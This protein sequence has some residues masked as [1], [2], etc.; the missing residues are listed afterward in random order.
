MLAVVAFRDTDMPAAIAV[1][2]RAEPNAASH[3][4]PSFFAGLDQV[5]RPGKLRRSKA[6]K[7]DFR[8]GFRTNK[9]P[10]NWF[11]Y[12]R[13][14]NGFGGYP[15]RIRPDTKS[16]FSEVFGSVRRRRTSPNTY[17]VPRRGLEPPRLAALVPETSASTN[18]AIW[19]R[20]GQPGRR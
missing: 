16:I 17:L 4:R 6:W 8:E 11:A 14:T 19:A 3:R 1:I 9:H 5:S 2:R 10:P 12:Q 20:A 15:R 13:R 7:R 18:S